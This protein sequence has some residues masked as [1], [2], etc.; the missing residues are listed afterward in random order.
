MT[1]CKRRKDISPMRGLSFFFPYFGLIRIDRLKQIVGKYIH[2]SCVIQ[3]RETVQGTTK[4]K[5]AFPYRYLH[6]FISFREI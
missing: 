1:V 5:S 4:N 6:G 3:N 2:L